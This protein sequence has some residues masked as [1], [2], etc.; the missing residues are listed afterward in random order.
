M[1]AQITES[2]KVNA[3]VQKAQIYLVN[4]NANAT[5]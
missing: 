1:N 4:V 3:K 2:E 5:F